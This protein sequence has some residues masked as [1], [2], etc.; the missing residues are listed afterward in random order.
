MSS[1]YYHPEIAPRGAVF[2]EAPE[3]EGWTDTR[4]P[5]PAP[6][7]PTLEE[8]V[9][10][11]EGLVQARLDNFARTLTYDGILSACTYATSQVEEYRIE[12]QYCVNARDATW[13]KAFELLNAFNP[14]DPVPIWAEVEAQLPVLAWPEGS[15]GYKQSEDN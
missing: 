4:I 8:T 9:A 15:R 14:G 1:T 5:E 3:G 10:K 11:Y 7:P 6:E 13:S 12:G 2:D